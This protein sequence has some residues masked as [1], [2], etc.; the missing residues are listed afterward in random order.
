MSSK[1]LIS[2]LKYRNSYYRKKD[3]FFNPMWKFYNPD[4]DFHG[5]YFYKKEYHKKVDDFHWNLYD[6]VVISRDIMNSLDLNSL[7]I[8]SKYF[9]SKKKMDL[10]FAHEKYYPI[11]KTFMNPLYSDH[12]PITFT[13]DIKKLN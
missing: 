6:Q 4:Y 5:T 12:L 1:N 9:N 8:V 11:Y 13:I 7:A 2:H 10:Y 3:I